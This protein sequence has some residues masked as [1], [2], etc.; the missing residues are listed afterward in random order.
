VSISR[1]M[2]PEHANP[3]GNVHGGAVM[4]MIDEAGAICAMRHARRPCVT[5]TVD[6]MT[7]YSPVRV[8]EVVTCNARVH[9]VGQTSMEVGVRVRA[10]NP[11]TG[12][13][14][15]TNSARLVYVALDDQGRPTSVPRLR[16]ES[17]DERRR[18]QAARQRHEQA[19][20][21]ARRG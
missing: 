11:L 9:Y 6:S 20:G 8:G 15:H 16:L 19:R 7:F 13:V 21:T 2:L 10:E 12:D 18:W 14:T 4:K 1:L 17:E 3:L 5:V